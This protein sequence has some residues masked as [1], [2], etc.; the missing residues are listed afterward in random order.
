MSVYHCVPTHLDSGVIE[1]IPDA[2]TLADIQKRAGGFV[3]VF[4]QEAIVSWLKMS[5]PEG[6]HALAAR[7]FGSWIPTCLHMLCCATVEDYDRAV[8]NFIE[9]CAGYCVATHV[10][11]IGDRHNDNVMITTTGRLF[12][13]HSHSPTHTCTLLSRY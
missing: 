2:V 12:R 5:N 1:V 8:Q 10:L 7:V 6:I 13:M 11:G 3:G 4:R 9:S